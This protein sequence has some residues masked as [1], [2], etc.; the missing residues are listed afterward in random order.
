MARVVQDQPNLFHP[1][2]PN[3]RK[4]IELPYHQIKG[5]MMDRLQA[6]LLSYQFICAKIKAGLVPQLLEDYA[7]AVEACS[8]REDY[9]ATGLR[10][11]QFQSF[12]NKHVTLSFPVK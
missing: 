5:E 6:T 2:V 7:L 4:L 3:M 11:K 10:L 8:T 12:V 1:N 9:A